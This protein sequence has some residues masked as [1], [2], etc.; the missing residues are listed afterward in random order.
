[1]SCGCKSGQSVQSWNDFQNMA[2]LDPR[3]QIVYAG[4]GVSTVAADWYL[5]SDYIQPALGSGWISSPIAVSGEATIITNSS[6]Q[7]QMVF[8]AESWNMLNKTSNVA[9]TVAPPLRKT[10][11]VRA[12]VQWY[13]SIPIGLG[14]SP[15]FTELQLSFLENAATR[16][17]MQGTVP[18]YRWA[19]GPYSGPSQLNL[20][21]RNTGRFTL[22]LL[23]INNNST[24]D[25]TMYE[26]DII[27]V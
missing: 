19:S 17:D 2:P 5:S 24:P 7:Q 27:A 21:F 3:D 11:F 25:W 6:D 12:G 26:L 9:S 1:M 16:G 20:V 23:G 13:N 14:S 22:G 15:A 18:V 8:D 4:L 10:V